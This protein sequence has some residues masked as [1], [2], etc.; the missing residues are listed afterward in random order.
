MDENEIKQK[1]EGIEA[2]MERSDFWNDKESAQAV[3][4]EYQE[5]KLQ[6]EGKERHDNGNA[7]VTIFSGAGGLDAEDFARM[8]TGMYLA[9]LGRN[10]WDHVVMHQNE[11]DHG[12][13]RNIT[14]EVQGKGAYGE[15]KH[16]EGV[17]RLVRISPF[18][19]KQQRHTSFVMVEVLP[20]LEDEHELEIPETDIDI[21][22]T[23][24]GGP[25]GQNVNKRET[26]VRIVHRPTGI[27]VHVATQRS[28]A[29]N[30]AYA[31][32]ILRGKLYHKEQEEKLLRARGLS[33]S[34][35][36]DAEWGNQIRSYVLHPYKMVKDHRTG[37]EVNNTDKVLQDG[38][39]DEFID[40]HKKMQTNSQVA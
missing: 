23:R 28:Q 14:F 15:L 1:I 3:L 39:I 38:D 26:A 5:L 22:F 21:Q 33:I 11:N 6:V 35:T 36:T 19:A 4:K 30:R 37:V 34:A 18:N 24:A 7:I 2:M 27:A 31:L 32:E 20:R 9:Y 13:I 8:L 17:H 25:G 16:E 10:G 12:G 40:A 29:Q